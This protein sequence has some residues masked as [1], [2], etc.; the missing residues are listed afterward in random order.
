MIEKSASR[1]RAVQIVHALCSHPLNKAEN[2]QGYVDDFLS[3]ADNMEDLEIDSESNAKF[4]RKLVC[5]CM[6]NIVLIDG[7]IESYIEKDWQM[8]RI[9]SI[10]LALARVGTSEILSCEKNPLK[11]IIREYAIISTM[12]IEQDGTGFVHALLDKIGN[13]VRPPCQ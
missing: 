5:Y 12:F 9:D 7:Q 4:L 2:L 11:V 3:L 1:I 8:D 13:S 10:C 6:E